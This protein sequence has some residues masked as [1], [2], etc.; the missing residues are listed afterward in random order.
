MN[1][2]ENDLKNIKYLE[3]QS[4]EQIDKK[5]VEYLL[6]EAENR[7]GYEG[8]KA[9]IVYK[10]LSCMDDF[11]FFTQEDEWEG[12]K[13][14]KN[15]EWA[16]MYEG[17]TAILTAQMANTINSLSKTAEYQVKIL[18]RLLKMRVLPSKTMQSMIAIMSWH[19][20]GYV[21]YEKLPCGANPY[22]PLVELQMMGLVARR[23]RNCWLV[24]YV[25][26]EQE[27]GHPL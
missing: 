23:L 27:K 5:K 20:I 15:S 24:G 26:P 11:K 18:C 7:F 17:K 22:A 12:Y 25:P 13:E 8:E 6:R 1:Y 4:F 14:K 19:S 2:S 9:E 21:G 16:K 3:R 10:S